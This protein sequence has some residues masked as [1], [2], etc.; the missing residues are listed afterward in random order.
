MLFQNAYEKI[1]GDMVTKSKIEPP[2]VTFFIFL[3]H[4][5][6]SEA[7]DKSLK[8]TIKQYHKSCL[9]PSFKTT[10][11]RTIIEFLFYSTELVMPVRSK[12]LNSTLFVKAF[13]K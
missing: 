8:K 6:K 1:D 4:L 2:N 13:T 7:W 10:W 3:Y 11:R 5:V 12:V 9:L